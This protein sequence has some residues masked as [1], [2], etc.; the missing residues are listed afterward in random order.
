[1]QEKIWKSE[2][3]QFFFEISLGIQNTRTVCYNSSFNF[4]KQPFTLVISNSPKIL[5]NFGM[6]LIILELKEWQYKFCDRVKQHLI[7]TG[8]SS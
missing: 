7:K 2:A 4:S 8:L 3:S 6:K 5:L 1:M